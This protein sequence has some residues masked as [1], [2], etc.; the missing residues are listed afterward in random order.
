MLHFAEVQYFPQISKY[1]LHFSKKCSY[2]LAH[3][4]KKHYLC[5]RIQ[6]REIGE[7]PIQTRCCDLQ[8]RLFRI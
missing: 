4:K 2:F 1:F 5:T 3:L 8:Y 7:N 6:L